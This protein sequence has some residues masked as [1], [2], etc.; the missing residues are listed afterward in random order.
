MYIRRLG[1]LRLGN[2]S[3]AAPAKSTIQVNASSIDVSCIINTGILV[4][5]FFVAQDGGPG[6][7]NGITYS[8]DS[9]SWLSIDLTRS[10]DGWHFTV[11]IDTDALVVGLNVGTIT[12]ADTNAGDDEVIT[13]NVTAS[14]QPYVPAPTLRVVP[15]SLVLAVQQGN[16][17]TVTTYIRVT[18]TNSTDLTAPTIG[19]ISGT[20]AAVVTTQRFGSGAVYEFTITV[21][22]GA[23][24]AA[25]SPYSA[26][27][28]VLSSGATNTPQNVTLSLQ[29]TAASPPPTP[30]MQLSASAVT[31]SGVEGSASTQQADITVTSG[32]GAALG[33]TSVGTVTGTAASVVSTSVTGHTVSIFTTPGALLAS[34]SPY[35]AT[36][37]IADSLASDS[38]KNVTLTY[39]VT[40]PPTGVTIP[41]EVRLFN[42]VAG[43]GVL[44]SRPLMLR[45]GDLTS[46]DE[47]ARKVRLYVGG[48][49]QSIY[50]KALRGR[51]SDGS[52]RAVLIQFRYD[53]P[54]TTPI[55]GT[56]VLG[57][58]RGTTD[59]AATPV[60]DDVTYIKS[61]TPF[62]LRAGFVPTDPSYLCATL[63]AGSPLIPAAQVDAV[64]YPLF[65]A[66]AND[67]Y[68]AL[69]NTDTTSTSALSDYE[70]PRGLVSLWCMTGDIKYY[71]AAISRM[72][73]LYNYSNDTSPTSYSP[74]HN[75]E[76]L[77]PA[78]AGV[79][80]PAE[81]KSQRHW[82][83]FVGYYLTGWPTFYATA[84]AGGQ[85][86]MRQATSYNYAR[87]INPSSTTS[88][89]PRNCMRNVPYMW[90]AAL[91]DATRTISSPSGAGVAASGYSAQFAKIWTDV[92][93]NLYVETHGGT[94]WR[95]GFPFHH[96]T[97][98]DDDA[99]AVQG[100][101]PLFQS[102]LVARHL[103]DYY[104]MVHANSAIPPLLKLM[105]DTLYLNSA[106]ASGNAYSTGSDLSGATIGG[107][108]YSFLQPRWGLP[109]LSKATPTPGNGVWTFPMWAPAIA[110]V[111]KYYGGNDPGGTPY[112]TWYARAVNVANVY[113]SGGGTGPLNWSW[114]V[115]AETFGGTQVASYLMSLTG[116]PTGPSAPPS[117]TV[118]TDWPT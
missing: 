78:G 61:T 38:P 97:Y 91:M 56:V 60:V 52:L 16:P 17:A 42:D 43:S 80:G 65:V 24:T 15:G 76:L 89:S 72:R 13:I 2:P 5:G 25:G 69:K 32:N 50:T 7:L 44:V 67:R 93:A 94:G 35:S 64:S 85:I 41:V 104:L 103:I 90:I 112:S 102:A 75:I 29:V 106:T 100:D 11:S 115:W 55:A 19:T 9:S 95:N 62:G 28:P 23:L 111:H 36:I 20:A 59:I 46:A 110:F 22:A 54:N 39:N 74:T 66:Y 21:T 105:V 86:G 12:L 109:Y 57:S 77:S 96:N 92:A 4:A 99:S 101:W 79:G 10:T 117:P 71:I 8:N 47:A 34:G 40:S 107:T 87:P 14:D 118:Y 18:S 58:V 98:Q 1:V 51:H 108:S 26:V 27:I 114:K 33:T 113:H 116:A 6:S 49:E 63:V 31:L 73:Y 83:W 37:P 3:G 68:D 53:I 84:N 82:T 30:T 81:A 70:H 88:H 45:P 48:V